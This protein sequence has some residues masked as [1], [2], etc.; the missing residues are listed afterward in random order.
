MIEVVLSDGFARPN[1]YYFKLTVI[2]PLRVTKSNLFNQTSFANF[3]VSKAS[4]RILSVGRDGKVKLKV[5]SNERAEDIVR[6]ITNESF[7]ITVPTKNNELVPY[8][9][10]F[11]DL[12]TMTLVISLNFTDPKKISNTIVR[13]FLHFNFFLEPRLTGNIFERGHIGEEREEVGLPSAQLNSQRLDSSIDIFLR[14][15]ICSHN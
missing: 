2:D 7:T 11:R 10:G 5:I 4:L 12:R 15:I 13:R 3:T 6:K 9:V 1:R 8:K 14:S